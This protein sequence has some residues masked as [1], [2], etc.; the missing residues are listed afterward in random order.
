MVLLVVSLVEVFQFAIV[1]QVVF[2]A[3]HEI[4]RL[5]QLIIN[6]ILFNGRRLFVLFC[7]DSLFD[8]RRI[9]IRGVWIQIV[10]R[11][12]LLHDIID[13]FQ[14]TLAQKLL[15][16]RQSATLVLRHSLV[17]GPEF[18]SM[19]AI[20]KG[21]RNCLFT[22]RTRF[23]GTTCVISIL[24][25]ALWGIP[26]FCLEVTGVTF[27]RYTVWW[28]ISQQPLIPLSLFLS[29]WK[30]VLAT[31]STVC[32]TSTPDQVVT[33]LGNRNLRVVLH[34]IG[35]FIALRRG[36]TDELFWTV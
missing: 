7:F 19:I 17:L 13:S 28:S 23:Q 12:A 9:R 26:I 14:A 27:V 4:F 8:R 25:T 1:M 24:V 31:Q 10:S 20:S 5:E 16:Q 2:F 22:Q 6:L 11:Q 30:R 15:P 34:T 35:H 3:L 33:F 21:G 32:A 29:M 18:I 36:R